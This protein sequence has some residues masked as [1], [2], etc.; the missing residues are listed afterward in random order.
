MFLCEPIGLFPCCDVRSVLLCVLIFTIMGWYLRS[1]DDIYDQGMICTIMGWYLRV[2]MAFWDTNLCRSKS[3]LWPHNWH[4]TSELQEDTT[5]LHTS[6][7]R[8]P[9]NQ[10][11]N[12]SVNQSIN[13]SIINTHSLPFLDG[14]ITLTKLWGTSCN[15]LPH[16]V[17]EPS[18]GSFDS[19]RHT[20]D[21]IETSM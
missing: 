10:S 5:W 4:K 17:S 9:I 21:A 8:I 7:N 11:I 16:N 12:Q 1:W 14:R 18:A 2:F 3:L 13:Q 15:R 6:L 20:F 19:S